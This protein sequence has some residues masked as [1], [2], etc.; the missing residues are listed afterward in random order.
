MGEVV[1]AVGLTRRVL[2]RRFQEL[3]G[4]TPRD[5]IARHRVERMR[6]LLAETDLTMA[7]IA[8]RTGF[9]HV[10]YATVVL[11]ARDRNIAEHVP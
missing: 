5:E 2:D 8:L 7:E 10:E 11:P 4:R 3:T 9:D 6:Q 1:R